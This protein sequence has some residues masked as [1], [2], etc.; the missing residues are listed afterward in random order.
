MY[1][2]C[3]RETTPMRDV[4]DLS[5]STSAAPATL[6]I[7]A[8]HIGDDQ[9]AC[10]YVRKPEDVA[11]PDRDW[12]TL[13]PGEVPCEHCLDAIRPAERRAAQ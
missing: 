1:Y 3:L 7:H 13:Q 5:G 6:R 9:I 12:F 11:E 10:P 4:S 8:L 2:A